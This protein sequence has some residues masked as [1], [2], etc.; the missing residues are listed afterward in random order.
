M[1]IMV[2]TAR[3]ALGASMAKI[4]PAACEK[5]SMTSIKKALNLL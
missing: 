1:G 4:D 5:N 2:P 3:M